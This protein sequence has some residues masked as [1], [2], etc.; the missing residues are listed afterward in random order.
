MTATDGPKRAE[1]VT[2]PPRAGVATE[3]GSNGGTRGLGTRAQLNDEVAVQCIRDAQQRVDA[4]RPPAGLEPRDRGL[5]RPG[6]LGEPALGESLFPA[7]LR[8]PVRDCGEEPTAVL[9][10]GDPFAQALDRLRLGPSAGPGLV[11][12]RML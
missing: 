4:R 6:Q 11:I 9:D 5:C 2:F 8:D 10:A 7:S 12:A 1:T 3:A